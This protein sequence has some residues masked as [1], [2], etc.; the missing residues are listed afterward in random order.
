MPHICPAMTTVP[1]APRP[2]IAE[3]ISYAICFAKQDQVLPG[4]S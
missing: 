3:A 1:V 4:Q 2:H